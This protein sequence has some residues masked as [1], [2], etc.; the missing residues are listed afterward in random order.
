MKSE[1]GLWSLNEMEQS[2]GEPDVVGMDKKPEKFYSDC[3][4]ESPKR[5]KEV[6]VMIVPLLIQEKHKPK[7]SAV[8]LAAAMGMNC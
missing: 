3:S 4:P 8:D 6:C 5:Q 7:N 2:G 1:A